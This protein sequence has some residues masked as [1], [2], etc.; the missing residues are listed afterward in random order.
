V[1]TLTQPAGPRSW[2]VRVVYQTRGEKKEI[3]L[4]LQATLVSEVTV[5]PANMVVAADHVAEH[6]FLLKETRPEPLQ[7]VEARTNLAGV[8][9]QVG[10]CT[11]DDHNAWQRSLRLEVPADMPLG[12]HEA[13]LDLY[14]TDAK[15]H[16]LQIPFTLVKQSLEQVSFA[17]HEVEIAGAAGQPLP[18]RLVIL[19]AQA[20]QDIEIEA[21]TADHPAISCRWASQPGTAATVRVQIDQHAVP[22]GGLDSAIHIRLR[23]PGSET[24]NVPVSCK[25]AAPPGT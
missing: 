13:R 3:V 24:L 10:P 5:T 25:L 15:Y 17:P 22:A 19:R 7:I 14:T 4:N 12:R 23:K 11:R 16:H 1:R 9:V 8:R 18:S 21:V 2:P 20:G 6:P